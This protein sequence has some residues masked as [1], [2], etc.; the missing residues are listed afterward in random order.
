MHTSSAFT[1]LPRQRRHPTDIETL[2]QRLGLPQTHAR[3]AHY[4]RGDGVSREITPDEAWRPWRA[5]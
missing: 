4:R 1:G 2:P 5:R 3:A